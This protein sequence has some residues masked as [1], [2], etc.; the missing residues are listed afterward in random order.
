MK[1][2]YETVDVE[3]VNR[4]IGIK[5]TAGT[6]AN[7]LTKMCLQSEVTDNGDTIRVE[8]PPT[9]PGM[10]DLTKNNPWGHHIDQT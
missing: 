7:H 5:E 4:N 2:R 9:R 3:L 6:I 1:Y 8:V 10:F